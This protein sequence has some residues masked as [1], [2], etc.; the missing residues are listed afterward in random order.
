MKTLTYRQA[1][2]MAKKNKGVT[3]EHDAGEG[4][5]GRV[6]FCIWRNRLICEVSNDGKIWFS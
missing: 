6:Y 3:F 2:N 1:C 4:K 5:F